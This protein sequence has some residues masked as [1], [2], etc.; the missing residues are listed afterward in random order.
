[1]RHMRVVLTQSDRHMH[2]ARLYTAAIAAAHAQ[3]SRMTVMRR[4]QEPHKDQAVCAP[5]LVTY[6]VLV[7]HTT[8]DDSSG[9]SSNTAAPHR[10]AGCCRQGWCCSHY[11]VQLLQH[12]HQAAQA[13]VAACVPVEQPQQHQLAVS[14]QTGSHV[15]HIVLLAC[16]EVVWLPAN[17]CRHLVGDSAHVWALFVTAVVAGVAWV[18]VPLVSLCRIFGIGKFLRCCILCMGAY[19]WGLCWGVLQHC[20]GV[21]L[22]AATKQFMLLLK[23]LP[24]YVLRDQATSVA[25]SAQQLCTRWQDV[26]CCRCSPGSGPCCCG[27]RC[28]KKQ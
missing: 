12:T 25:V 13:K 19:C 28:H 24:G 26:V 23:R 5:A 10:T 2:N 21:L 17:W 6:A 27:Q 16:C 4:V 11:I 14:S 1:M 22:M 15:G 9:S 18:C 3:K 7:R 20:P 8:S